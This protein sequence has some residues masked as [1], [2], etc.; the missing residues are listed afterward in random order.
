MVFDTG[1][2]FYKDVAQ[3]ER[4]RPLLKVRSPLVVDSLNFMDYDAANVG[5][6]DLLLPKEMLTRAASQ[7]AFPFLSANL[8]DTSGNTLFEPYLVKAFGSLRVGVIGLVSQRIPA[9][10]SG[11]QSPY[12]VLD[13]VKTARPLVKKLRES[14][15]VIVAL[16][17]LGLEDDRRLAKSVEGIDVILGGLSKKVMY[18]AEVV[19]GA[20]IVQAGSKGMRMG[21]L[22]MEVTPDRD[23]TWVRRDVAAGGEAKIYTWTPFSLNKRIKDHP[24]ITARL[25]EYRALLKT[26]EIARKVSPTPGPSSR[27]AGASECRTC[28][29]REGEQWGA[30]SHARAFETLLRKGQEGNPDCLECH[31]TAFR[32]KGGYRPGAESPDLAAVQC[33]A[34]HGAGISH[35]SRGMIDLMVPVTVCQGCHNTENSPTFRYEEYLKKLGEHTEGYFRRPP[36]LR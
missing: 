33:E 7:A 21:T 20:I 36:A 3:L 26:E 14:C 23:G 30:T 22:E 18:Q 10:V 2:M 13:P 32:E 19:G 29:P 12:R 8:R 6:M 5:W 24:G 31:V 28:H 16:T 34:C 35:K 9:G 1:D 15:D 17:S 27:Y 11:R 25:E 4:E